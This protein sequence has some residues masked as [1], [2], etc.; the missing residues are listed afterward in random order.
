MD[1]IGCLAPYSIHKNQNVLR[2]KPHRFERIHFMTTYS[3]QV[4]FANGINQHVYRC[5]PPG[6][7]PAVILLHGVT[8]NGMCWVRVADAL[9]STYDVIMPDARGHGLSDRPDGG[10]SVE[11]R[12]ADV[13]ALIDALELDRPVLMGHSLGGGLASVVAALYPDK[14]RALVL[15]DPAWLD[16]APDA[17]NIKNSE[18]WCADL[19]QQQ[20]LGRDGLIETI[21]T[22]Q[23]GW[24]AEELGP[25]ADGKLQ[26]SEHA[27]REIILH[28]GHNWRAYVAQIQCPTLLVT[29]DVERGI[30]INPTLA[31]EVSALN[32]LVREARIAQAGHSIHRDQFEASMQQ[33]Q[34][35]LAEVG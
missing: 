5:T 25:W 26:M 20:S 30:I 27:L 24:H 13:A 29:G 21:Q 28:I 6:G 23:P 22:E 2:M 1:G 16:S 8:D 7:G 4:I 17:D 33:I 32:S 34:D 14:V 12:A 15:E 35:F 18:K 3:E 19:R 10:Y 9:C 31:A 11:E